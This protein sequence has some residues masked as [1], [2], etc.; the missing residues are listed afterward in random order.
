MDEPH[1]EDLK[2]PY[3][4][5]LVR[6]QI[7]ENASSWLLRLTATEK[8][9]RLLGRC[10]TSSFGASHIAVLVDKGP[11]KGFEIAM[12]A[13]ITKLPPSLIKLEPRSC[14]VKELRD[15]TD[16]LHLSTFSQN[17]L[18]CLH[19]EICFPIFS[20]HK[21]LLI[22]MLAVGPRLNGL[23][24]EPDTVAF[25]HTLSNDIAVE[26][27]KETYYHNSIQDPLTGLFNR[28]HLDDT[29][30]KLTETGA[31]GRMAIALL[32]V[33][34]FKKINDT[35]GHP[36]GD[37]ILKI[38][39]EKIRRNVRKEDLCFRYGGEEFCILF[40]DLVKRDGTAVE[41]RSTQ[42]FTTVHELAER[43]RQNIGENLI[44]MESAE[45]GVT[46]S[47]GLSFWETGT[48]EPKIEEHLREA[49]DLLY[50]AKRAGRNRLFL[51]CP[52]L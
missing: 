13:G 10:L 43:L 39:S 21:H 2:D 24:Y 45:I 36:A 41:G 16:P 37:Q 51:S 34:Y 26:V 31:G 4:E 1:N 46:I 17:E 20:H 5:S 38:V 11:A 40:R 44:R 52:Y 42:F 32:D 28:K 19:I 30:L 3:Q 35:Y 23:S 50:A 12:S 27:E 25:F 6:Q 7:L 9:L 49:D 14:I 47:I 29:I 48:Q 33:D 22:G 15:H 8:F 18:N